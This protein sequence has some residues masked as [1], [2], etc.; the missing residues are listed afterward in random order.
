[1]AVLVAFGVAFTASLQGSTAA[2]QTAGDPI[3][4]GA[5]SPVRRFRNNMLLW[6]AWV[7]VLLLL[8]KILD[9]FHVNWRQYWPL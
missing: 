3:T 6:A 5:D 9:A 4:S 1:M 8:F 7:I 2:S